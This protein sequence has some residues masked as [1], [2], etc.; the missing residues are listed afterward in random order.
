MNKLFILLV[1]VGIFVIS[2]TDTLDKTT[3]INDKPRIE[4]S[5]CSSC[6]ECID[7]FNCPENAI[8]LDQRTHAAYIDADLC[9]GCMDCLNLFT[10]PDD[11][12]T[13]NVDNIKPAQIK[14]IIAAS[15][16]IGIMNIQFTATGDDSTSGRAFNYELVLRDSN[17]R[18]IENDFIPTLPQNAGVIENWNLEN[19]PANEL[20]KLEIKAFDELDQTS[21]PAL[22][23]VY[24]LG[25][26]IDEVPPAPIEDITICSISMNSFQINWTAPGDDG[27]IGASNYY[28]IKIHTENIT[29][30]NWEM[31]EEYEQNI[32]PQE[33]GNE[34]F[35]IIVDL[36]PI[37]EYY[38]GIKAID[39]VENISLLSNI[40]QATTTDIPDEI[41]PSAINDLQAEPTD[42][43]IE[44]TWTSPGDDGMQGI[45]YNYEIRISQEEITEA[46][47]E[48][49]E[50]LE[51]PPWPLEAGSSQNYI[52]EDLQHEITYFFAIKAFDES[53]NVSLLSNV[54]NTNLIIDIMPPS[55]ITDLTV[56]EGSTANLNTIKIQWTSPGD[57]G[58][59]G[60]ANHYEIKYSTT[61]IT[62]S[63]WESAALFVDPPVPQMAG[64][65]QFCFVNVLQPA[66]IYYFAIKAFDENNNANQISNSPAGKIVYQI[67][68]A[69]CHN[70]SNCIYDCDYGAILQ[71]PGYKYIEPDLCEACGDC[72]CPWNLIHRAVVAY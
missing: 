22:E 14:N 48:D 29:E 28:I 15:D 23:E 2:C 46:N 68:T 36:E 65:S 18:I 40:A 25:E 57:N 47:W 55:D 5:D 20:V 34:E 19:L 52:V 67:N 44:L 32:I 21:I 53:D 49:A 71:G 58:N 1:F 10:C 24:I 43:I 39:E 16:T 70:C 37:T 56:Y 69:A 38:V 42:E 63:N 8:K 3:G 13:L 35:L 9:S 59:Q 26:I 62:E 51:D 6:L 31:I 61:E 72:T 30:S 17:D 64:N 54:P 50:L 33:S 4:Y 41:P 12:F 66:T 11:A 27:N 7:L 60:T 45:A